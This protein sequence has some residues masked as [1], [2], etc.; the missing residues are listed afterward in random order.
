MLCTGN[1]EICGP[2][3]SPNVPAVGESTGSNPNTGTS[4]RAAVERQRRLAASDYRDM[5]M[6]DLVALVVGD[7]ESAVTTA[8]DE[9]ARRLESEI[10][11]QAARICG[12]LSH[13]GR[14]CP[15]SE[16]AEARVSAERS[17][18]KRVLGVDAVMLREG[19]SSSLVPMPRER[20]A[21]TTSPACTV[22]RWA[23]S[24]RRSSVGLHA[25]MVRE[26]TRH[27]GVTADARRQWNADRGLKVRLNLRPGEWS[28]LEAAAGRLGEL[29]RG[30]AEALDLVL[31]RASLRSLADRLYDDACENSTDDVVEVDVPRLLR[32]LGLDDDSWS[33]DVARRT[34]DTLVL[35]VEASEA[36]RLVDDYLRPAWRLTRGRCG[37]HGPPAVD[38][39]WLVEPGV[40]ES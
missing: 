26:I 32:A 16:C 6:D 4:F 11:R 27:E 8:L 1:G 30:L 34:F 17:L 28:A 31:A 29:D 19:R 9:L 20:K 38:V 15:G 7:G 2:E 21:R 35:A 22:K 37:H 13:C 40:S 33:L 10:R 12:R 23:S 14:R 36:V 5:S 18:L 25:F 3:G 39:E 24:P